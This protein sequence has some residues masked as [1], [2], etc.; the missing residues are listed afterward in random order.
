MFVYWIL[1]PLLFGATLAGLGL[2]VRKLSVPFSP[3]LLL[4]LGYGSAVLLPALLPYAKFTAQFAGP[5]LVLLAIAGWAFSYG[6]LRRA[7]RGGALRREWP[8]MVV[9]LAAILTFGAAVLASGVPTYTGYNQIVDI[10]VQMEWAAHLGHFGRDSLV[11]SSTAIRD[12]NSTLAT[13]YPGGPQ[14][15]LGTF[16]G[17][18]GFQ[19]S[20]AWEPYLAMIA[21]CLSLSAYAL[22]RLVTPSRLFAALGA[23]AVSQASPMIGYAHIGGIKELSGAAAVLTAGALLPTLL[24]PRETPAWRAALPFTIAL[25]TAFSVFSL[26]V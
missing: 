4:P 24:A 21:G 16:P 9:G 14:A 12:I 1:F 3:A 10:A 13:G 25:S 2:G 11:G 19:I 5:L 6:D 8:W 26:L 17:V 20:W 7:I 15:V 23:F 18:F 22:I